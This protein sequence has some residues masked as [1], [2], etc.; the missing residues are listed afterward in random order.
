MHPERKFRPIGAHEIDQVRREVLTD[1]TTEA[2]FAFRAEVVMSWTLLLQRIGFDMG[3]YDAVCPKSFD[4]SAVEESKRFAWV[5]QAF[6]VLEEMF[7]SGKMMEPIVNEKAPSKST[8]ASTANWPQ[9]QGSKTLNGYSDIEGPQRGEHAWKVGVGMAWYSEPVVENDS[10]YVVSP[11]MRSHLFSL[12]VETGEE[13]WRTK[14][15]TEDTLGAY[16]HPYYKSSAAGSPVVLSDR[17]LL[18]ELGSGGDSGNAKHVLNI[19]KSSGKLQNQWTVGHVDYRT[20]YP[21]CAADE[22]IML[23]MN[24]SHNIGVYSPQAGPMTKLDCYSSTDGE[25]LWSFESGPVMSTPTLTPTSVIV[26]TRDGNVFCLRRDKSSSGKKSVYVNPFEE[27]SRIL[28]QLNLNAP[29]SGAIAADEE[30]AYIACNDG[31][32]RCVCLQSGDVRWKID[33]GD[34]NK[35]AFNLFSELYLTSDS[36]FVGSAASRLSCLSKDDGSLKWEQSTEDWIRARPVTSGDH[37]VIA[38]LSGNLAAFHLAS[39]DPV[40]K[41]D[42]SDHAILANLAAAG[43][44]ILVNSSG[45]K[46]Y[47]LSAQDGSVLWE[48][49]IMGSVSFNGADHESDTLGGG[50]FFQSSPTIVDGITYV[51]TPSRFLCAHQLEDGA[52]LWRFEVSSAISSAPTVADGVVYF[53]QQGG[54]DTFFAI[55]AKTGELLWKQSVGWVWS[56]PNVE[57]DY[58]FFPS[59]DGY[60]YCLN[61]GDGSIRWRYR[62]G[63]AAYPMPSIADGLVV[64]GSWDGYYYAI[65]IASGKLAWKFNTE[66]IPDSG[67]P[68]IYNGKIYITMMG[69]A[70]WCL[71]LKTGKIAW[72]HSEKGRIFHSTIAVEGEQMFVGTGFWTKNALFCMNSKDG[73]LQWTAPGGGFCPPA[74]TKKNAY[75]GSTGCPFIHCVVRDP[76]V[77]DAERVQWRVQLGNVADEAGLAISDDRLVALATDYYLHCIQ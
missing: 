54:D 21:I 9:F 72:K 23:C 8:S 38:D 71:D 67:A 1:P 10:V 51:G 73:S 28:W 66:G 43:E 62:T 31:T 75:Y 77:S 63:Y 26:G 37:I 64:F 18:R 27:K 53:G 4:Y 46:T 2:N 76:H 57:G 45:L 50:G 47:A 41:S 39:G 74:L 42:V 3:P 65:N 19:D 48:R 59:S 32:I 24:G 36:I 22:S 14:P 7:V 33:T 13:K 60:L 69:D 40:W 49:T 56:C 25:W 58:V 20:G 44:K 5:D 55:D 6:A 34:C 17:I 16:L 29:I 52:L 68:S 15:S 70:L 30:S 35:H 61:R 12:D 11:G